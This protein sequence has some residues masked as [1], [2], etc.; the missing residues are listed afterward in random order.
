MRSGAGWRS[1]P[2]LALFVP[3]RRNGTG[4]AHRPGSI[5]R[6]HQGLDAAI[7]R[8]F[9]ARLPGAGIVERGGRTAA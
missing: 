8:L 6:C 2:G 3:E 7:P 5:R 4:D 9:R 1:K